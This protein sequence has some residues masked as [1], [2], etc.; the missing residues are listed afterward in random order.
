MIIAQIFAR[1]N[2][3]TND[4]YALGTSYTSTELVN[5]IVRSFLKAYQ[6][7]VVAIREAR[8]LSKLPLE[9]LMGSLMTH[10]IM[11][12]DYDKDEEAA[13]KKKTIA[14]KSF[15]QEEEEEEEELNDSEL[16]DIT[17][18]TRRYKNYLKF[19][20]GNKLKKYSK[21]NSLKEYSKGITTKEKKGNDE[22]TC[23]ECKKPRHMKNE[24]PLRRKNKKKAMKDTWD[25]NSESESNDEVQEQ[26]ANMCFM[27]IDSEV[28]KNKKKK[29]KNLW[30]MDSGC[31][32]HM[33]GDFSKFS[34]FTKNDGEFVTFG[35]NT[36]RKII[37]IGNIGNYS[38][39]I[40]EFT[41]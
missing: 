29:N 28:S 2:T 19:K 38:P 9:E 34:T 10:E 26:V 39:S 20:K 30:F 16:D 35:D 5:K 13:N 37:G 25:D 24:C 17:L 31:S 3:I 27:A 4:L 41:Y 33:T 32:K 15:T 6:R 36:K 11:I 14:L 12:R 21:G 7:K 23:F 22:V 8:V 18:L 1:F 40:I